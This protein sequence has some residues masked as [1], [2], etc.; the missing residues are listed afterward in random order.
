MQSIL[1]IIFFSF[2]LLG[3]YSFYIAEGHYQQ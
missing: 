3:K 1:E 2:S